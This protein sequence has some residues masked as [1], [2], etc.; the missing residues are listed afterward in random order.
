MKKLLLIASL[1]TLIVMT[2]CVKK[3]PV[4]YEEYDPNAP[5]CAELDD[6]TKQTFPSMQELENYSGASFLHDGPCY[7]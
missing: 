5:V 1:F 2:G 7:E 6:G 4:V 3:A